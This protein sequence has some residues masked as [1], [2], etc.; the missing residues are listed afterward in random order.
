[1]AASTGPVLI[2]A[3]ITAFSELFLEPGHGLSKLNWRIVPAAGGLALALAGLEKL[4]PQFAVGLAWLT[5]LTVL[6]VPMGGGPPPVEAA[7]AALGYGGKVT[8]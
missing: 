8:R 2:A 7:A 1:M 3:G 5:V 4:A 6:I